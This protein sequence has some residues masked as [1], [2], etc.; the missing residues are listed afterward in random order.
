MRKVYLDNLTENKK[1]TLLIGKDLILATKPYASENRAKSWLYAGSTFALLALSLFGTWFSNYFLLKLFC[2]VA[3]GLLSSR[4]FVIYH[5]YLH[6]AILN[7]SFLAKIIM[8]I[9]GIYTLAPTSIW[10]RSHDYH[11]KHNSKLYSASIGSYPIMTKK[12]FLAMTAGQRRGYL[13]TRSPL[14][15]LL[16][17]FSMFFIGMC[18]NSFKASPKKH[19][20][21]LIAMVVHVAATIVVFWFGGWQAW[22]L[23]IF[24]PFFIPGCLG[25]YLFYA[26]HNFPTA[27]FA[28]NKDWSYET[29]AMQ[30]SSF[31]VMSPFMNW[32]TANIGYHHIHHL[33]SRV[34]F[35]RLPE[36]MEAIPQLQKAKTTTLGFKDVIACMKLKVWDPER[37][38]LISLKELHE[39]A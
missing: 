19:I 12:K 7:K 13:A 11:H 39:A 31:L 37:D 28:E 22:V 27:S 6:H 14:T 21:S 33:N 25:A 32:V 29:A 16:G 5:D 2:S 8:T 23:T 1:A 4:M 38:R 26:Q 17:Y 35:Y 20:D 15:I 3:A 24:I 30:S 34:P 36:V 18:Y 10:K 9:F